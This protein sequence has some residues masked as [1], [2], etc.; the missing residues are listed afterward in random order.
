M[1]SNTF[2]GCAI[3]MAN[4]K[5]FLLAYT[6]GKISPKSKIKNVTTTTST[7]NFNT[8]DAIDENICSLKY[9]NKI[10]I[11]MLMKLFATKIVANSFFGRSNRDA[12]IWIRFALS[13]PMSLISDLVNENKATSA[14]EIN[15]EPH[16]KRNSK[17]KP[18][19]TDMSIA[20]LFMIKLK[21]S[22][23]KNLSIS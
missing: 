13:S 18:D 11:P 12:I 9:A 16:N 19:A 23:S 14:P 4:F 7:T 21:G 6:F 15:A 2:K 10:T 8:G 1:T 17:I 3:N 5:L 20:K 22:G